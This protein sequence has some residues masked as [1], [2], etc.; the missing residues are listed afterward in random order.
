VP[1]LAR[2][3]EAA[4]TEARELGWIVWRDFAALMETGFL[5]Y[6][7]EDQGDQDEREQA[8]QL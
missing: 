2:A 1:S 7:S 8:E 4:N 6:P 3:W 5:E